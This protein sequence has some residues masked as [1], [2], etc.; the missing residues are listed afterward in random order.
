MRG[1]ESSP[2]FRRNISLNR[3]REAVKVKMIDRISLGRRETAIMKVNGT[4]EE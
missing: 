3:F 4:C 1:L 2:D